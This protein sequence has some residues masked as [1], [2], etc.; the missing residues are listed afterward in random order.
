MT[1]HK[2]SCPIAVTEQQESLF[3]GWDSQRYALDGYIQRRGANSVWAKLVSG[4]T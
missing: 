1:D 3:H 4:V 2:T